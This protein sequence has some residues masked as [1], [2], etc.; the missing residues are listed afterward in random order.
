MNFLI[1]R[2]T[3]WADCVNDW[4]AISP[5]RDTS[6]NVDDINGAAELVGGRYGFSYFCWLVTYAVDNANAIGCF[7]YFQF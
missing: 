2:E 3:S 5:G 7:K 4:V 1:C 6:R